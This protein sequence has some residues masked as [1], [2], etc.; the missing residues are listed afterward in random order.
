M[1]RGKLSPSGWYQSLVGAG[2]QPK[3]TKSDLSLIWLVLIPRG[4]GQVS[5]TSYHFRSKQCCNEIYKLYIMYIFTNIKLC[6][7][8]ETTLLYYKNR[9]RN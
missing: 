4:G 8:H 6:Q 3:V 9:L 1:S 2:G 7:W 5:A